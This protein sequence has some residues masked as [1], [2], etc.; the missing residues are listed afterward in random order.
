MI[1]TDTDTKSINTLH[2]KWS[3]WLHKTIVL[4]THVQLLQKDYEYYA[5]LET[6]ISSI[7]AVQTLMY[8]HKLSVKCHPCEFL[9]V[10]NCEF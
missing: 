4:C 1:I 10:Y 8:T 9:I 2:G 7:T 6:G 5:N 3:A